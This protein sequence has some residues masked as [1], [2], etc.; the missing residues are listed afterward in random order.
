MHPILSSL[1]FAAVILLGLT[2]AF[3]AGWILRDALLSSLTPV[4]FRPDATGAE[5]AT[6]IERYY[7]RAHLHPLSR[8]RP[9]AY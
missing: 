8:R 2:G 6:A 1:I 5:V 7:A 3:L 9:R 4:Q